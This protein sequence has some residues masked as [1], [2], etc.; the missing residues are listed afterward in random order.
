MNHQGTKAPRRPIAEEPNQ[1]AQ[2][3]VDSVF[4]VHSKRGPRLLEGVY[5]VCLAHEAGTRG[6]TD[7]CRHTILAGWPNTGAGHGRDI[8][9]ALVSKLGS[10]GLEPPENWREIVEKCNPKPASG[11]T[12]AFA[13]PKIQAG[14][15]R[16][17]PPRHK[18]T[19]TAHQRGAQAG[20]H[21]R[22]RS[23]RRFHPPAS[24]MKTQPSL[25]YRVLA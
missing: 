25:A 18:G 10:E 1:L 5:E 6:A 11:S 8:L 19:N 4:K 20:D 9:R 14:I 16:Y 24:R 13:Q 15:A 7:R 22:G 2:R 12:F 17:E 23:S 21:R 3:V